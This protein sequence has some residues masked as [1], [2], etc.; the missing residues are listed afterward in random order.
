VSR[1]RLLLVPWI[2]ELEWRIKPFLE[3]WADVAS[4]DCPGVGDEPGVEP[5]DANA[6]IDRGLAELDRLGWDRCVIVSDEFGTA[7]AVRIA[8]ARPDVVEGMAL[9]HA[10][11]SFS[12]KGA[13]AP[14]SSDMMA[15]FNRLLDTDYRAWVRAYTQITQGAYDE[16]TMRLFLERV[17]P[18]VCKRQSA[19]VDALTA[20]T[21]V[22][23]ALRELQVPLLFAEHRDCLVFRREGFEQAVAAFPQAET[24]WT[25]EK[26]SCSPAFAEKLRSFTPSRVAPR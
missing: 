1:P 4:Y 9:G 12:E 25:A 18:A 7:I 10:C 5:H 19:V 22:E 8:E 11:L 2:T 3:E 16:E 23:A 17:P 13:D 26:P 6:V 15:G 24:M 20:D 14:V 21:D